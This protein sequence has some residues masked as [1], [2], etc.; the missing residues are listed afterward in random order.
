MRFGVC[1][2][3]EPGPAL[4]AA[5]FDYLELNV[6]AHLK[7][8]APD[9]EFAAVLARIRDCPLPCEAANCFVPGHLRITG[10][11]ADL[12]ALERYVRT[13][14]A[15]AR[16]AGI[17]TIVFGSG[18]ARQIPEGCERATAW[19]QIVEFSRMAAECAAREQVV[20]VVE[21]LNRG[22]CNV[23][24]SVT[25]GAA[26]VREVNHAALRLLVDA[27]HWAREAESPAAIVAAGGLLQ[28]AH[29][30]TF[31]NRLAPSLEPCDFAPFFRAC[32]TAGY[33]GRVS[34][35]GKWHDMA[36]D[37]APVLAALRTAAAA[38]A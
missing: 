18:G 35:E 28:H 5:G 26:L 2:G 37:A 34:V 21:P 36:A 25:E 27:F 30:A 14:C 13:A 38:A 29:I 22:E 31:A 17:R 3:P 32:R 10:P 9:E 19:R 15:R 7:P 33:D 1:T 16:Q 11:Q 8:E 20:L 6:Q 24:N 12:A 4:A 23:L